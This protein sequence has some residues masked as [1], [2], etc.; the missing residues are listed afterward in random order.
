MIFVYFKKMC[1][2]LNICDSMDTVLGFRDHA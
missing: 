2:E 1:V